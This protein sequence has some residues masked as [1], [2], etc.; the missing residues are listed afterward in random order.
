MRRFVSRS[1]HVIRSSA[2]EATRAGASVA[3]TQTRGPRL[4]GSEGVTTVAPSS[5]SPSIRRVLSE[6]TC[7]ST[8]GTPVSWSSSRPATPA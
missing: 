2:R 8:A 6:A 4:A 5:S 3:A 7:A 1:E